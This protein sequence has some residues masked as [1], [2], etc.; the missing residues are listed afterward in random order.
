MRYEDLISK[1]HAIN[2][3]LL[4]ALEL[5]QNQFFAFQKQSIEK[6]FN[7][8]TNT[9]VVLQSLEDYF[10]SNEETKNNQIASF[11]SFITNLR[12]ELEKEVAQYRKTH[13]ADMDKEHIL[14]DKENQLSGFKS[15]KKKEVQ[16]LTQRINIL[17]RDCIALL[18]TNAL[19]FEE[20]EKVHKAKL[21]DIEKKMKYEVQKVND[22]ILTPEVFKNIDESNTEKN[23]ENRQNYQNNKDIKELRRQGILEIA[24]IKKK[25]LIELKEQE[26]AFRM[27]ACN[28]K[29]DNEILR[30]EYNLQIEDLKLTKLKLLEDIQTEVDMYDFEAYRT[31]FVAN[32]KYQTAINQIIDK[33]RIKLYYYQEEVIKAEKEKNLLNLNN[34]HNIYDKVKENDSKQIIALSTLKEEQM[35]QLFGH[36][37]DLNEFIIQIGITYRDLMICMFEQF[38]DQFNR[39]VRQFNDTLVFLEFNSHCFQGFDY[40]KYN[41]EILSLTEDFSKKQI[42][43]FENFKKAT[44]SQFKKLLRQVKSMYQ[45][46]VDF[47]QQENEAIDGFVASLETMV[48]DAHQSGRDFNV[49]LYDEISKQTEEKELKMKTEQKEEVS[50]WQRDNQRIQNEYNEK[51]QDLENKMQIYHHKKQEV[52]HKAKRDYNMTVKSIKQNIAKIKS[53]HKL[54]IKTA[55]K[56]ILNNHKEQVK[57][58]ETEKKTKLKIGLI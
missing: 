18:K 22:T 3:D 39:S 45:L 6:L 36:I 43:R 25:Y 42:F 23:Y 2:N 38:W 56:E 1:V 37:N 24:K 5:K 57:H 53:H 40:K 12:E 13:D 8:K 49:K 34:V 19:A 47:K 41:S 44:N 20:Q 31:V 17:D 52:M 33:Y 7:N 29:R 27:F 21:A 4:Q 16:E 10:Q 9:K 50:S 15:I 28:H 30:E 54:A 11:K 46:M 26:L 48:K 58:V 32:E 51:I 55:Q 14:K 35:G